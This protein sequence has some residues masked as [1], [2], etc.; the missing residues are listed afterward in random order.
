MKKHYVRVWGQWLEYRKAFPEYVL[1]VNERGDAFRV[2]RE[3]VTEL[4]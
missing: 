2:R 3:W 4:K 1:V